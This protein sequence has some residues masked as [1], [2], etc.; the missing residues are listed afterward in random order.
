[1]VWVHYVQEVLLGY[2]VAGST[3]RLSL[4]ILVELQTI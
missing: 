1:M 3:V 4:F 2:S